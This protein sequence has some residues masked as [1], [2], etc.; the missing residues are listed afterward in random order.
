[1]HKYIIRFSMMLTLNVCYSQISIKANLSSLIGYPQIG[2]EITLGKKATLELDYLTSYWQSFNNSPHLINM[3]FSECR[4]YQKK[5]K[6]GFYS[7]V[8]IG[9]ANYKL[10]KWN[11]L[12]TDLYQE[13]YSIFYGATIGYQT[14]INSKFSLDFFLGG[15]NQ[16]GYYKGFDSNNNRYDKATNFNKSGEWLVY[17]A[18]IMIAYKL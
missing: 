4:F 17:R 2:T 10:Q 15:G 12:H 9:V 13:G 18:G 6:F 11:Y 8:N 16:Q 3:L 1:M 5:S 7:G 14:E